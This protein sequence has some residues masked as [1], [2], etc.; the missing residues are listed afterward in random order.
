[1]VSEAGDEEKQSLAVIATLGEDKQVRAAPTFQL[2]SSSTS[3]IILKQHGRAAIVVPDNVV[4]EGGAGETVR[5][6]LL[7]QA[8]V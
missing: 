5:R 1:M 4:F 3:F 2:K 7:K 8:N 6:E